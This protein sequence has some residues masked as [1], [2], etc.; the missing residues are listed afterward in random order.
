[1][2]DNHLCKESM[3]FDPHSC[4]FDPNSWGCDSPKEDVA[5]HPIRGRKKPPDK[6]SNQETS[7]KSAYS[8]NLGVVSYD[9]RVTNIFLV[10]EKNDTRQ[11]PK[12]STDGIDFSQLI[13]KRRVHSEDAGSIYKVLTD[14]DPRDTRCWE[15]V[16][17]LKKSSQN[18]TDP[19]CNTALKAT[20]E[21]HDDL[22][23]RLLHYSLMHAL[24]N[25][26]GTWEDAKFSYGPKEHSSMETA[27]IFVAVSDKSQLEIPEKGGNLPWLK[28]SDNQV[29]IILKCGK[30]MTQVLQDDALRHLKKK[31][32]KNSPE[33]AQ[34]RQLRGPCM[35]EK[36]AQ[37]KLEGA[38]VENGAAK[39]G[40]F[41][42]RETG[43]FLTVACLFDK[44][45][46]IENI[47]MVLNRFVSHNLEKER[48]RLLALALM[49]LRVHF[50]VSCADNVMS[51]GVYDHLDEWLRL[52]RKEGR[53]QT[54][55]VVCALP[56]ALAFVAVWWDFS[57]LGPVFN[58]DID[59][60]LA[61]IGDFIRNAWGEMADHPIGES[62]SIL[63]GKLPHET[64]FTKGQVAQMSQGLHLREVMGGTHPLY[65]CGNGKI[66][67]ERK[68]TQYSGIVI[69]YKT[70]D[71]PSGEKTA[72]YMDVKPENGSLKV[73]V[74]A[75][76]V[77]T[78]YDQW[79]SN[80]LL[81]IVASTAFSK[82]T[83]FSQGKSMQWLVILYQMSNFETVAQQVQDWAFYAT[84]CTPIEKLV[85][86]QPPGS[87]NMG[88]SAA[89]KIAKQLSVYKTSSGLLGM[90]IYK[91]LPSGTLPAG[92][93]EEY[94]QQEI[95]LLYLVITAALT[96]WQI[97]YSP[98]AFTPS[99]WIHVVKNAN[100]TE[101][102][103]DGIGKQFRKLFDHM[104]E[105]LILLPEFEQNLNRCYPQL[106]L[107]FSLQS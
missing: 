67:Y 4:D 83:D 70:S 39:T 38:F 56:R 89:L 94:A 78:E 41:D 62:L 71:H 34:L 65:K 50:P 81:R 55:N 100:A 85:R 87:D 8:D 53:E 84:L 45:D 49:F 73:C 79:M 28:I 37:V 80:I 18:E 23:F 46:R 13:K 48:P 35:N 107:I 86:H 27:C 69:T 98:S 91:L 74:R 15:V 7:H 54:S 57:L 26:H 90:P 42:L 105:P 10:D 51:P 11:P 76:T 63:R 68:S 95:T 6:S 43:R 17:A 93:Q 33:D 72:L 44:N 82:C 96:V 92:F 61:E 97:K 1:M 104:I 66:N 59:Y 103:V 52:Q 99:V 24:W 25:C 77:L 5:W 102:Y 36:Q 21:I 31:N 32:L 88:A 64:V 12:R 19:T 9:K 14:L 29:T 75:E 20:L 106:S 60:R 2:S 58:W 101:L 22:L 30:E 3:D 47:A 16:Q 40:E